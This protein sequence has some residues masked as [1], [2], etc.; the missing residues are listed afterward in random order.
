M[1]IFCEELHLAQQLNQLVK[2]GKKTPRCAVDSKL[3]VSL[4]M[5]GYMD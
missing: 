5:L 1:M 2:T 3:R 4:F